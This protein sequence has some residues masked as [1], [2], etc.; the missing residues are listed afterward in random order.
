M[1][2]VSIYIHIPFCMHRCGYCDFNTYA[3]LEGLIP[4]YAQAVCNE[5]TYLSSIS[6]DPILVGTIYFGGGT[7][8][9][10]PIR[11]LENILSS[12]QNHFNLDESIEISLEANPG[13]VSKKFL[14]EINSLGVNRLSL[15]MQSSN[16][17]ELDLLER[18][19]RYV[20]VINAVEWARATGLKS[21]NLDLIFGLPEQSVETWMVNLESALS[22]NPEHLSL[23]ALTIEV[24]TPIYR[25]VK[26]GIFPE[27]DQ[28]VVADMYESASERLADAGFV[29]Y[30]ISNWALCDKSGGL[31]ACEHNLQYWRNLPYLGLGAGAHGFINHQRTINILNPRKYVDR[32]TDRSKRSGSEISFPWT[33]AVQEITPID[34]DTEIGETMMMGLRLTVEGVSTKKFKQ[35]YGMSLQERFGSQIDRL[36]GYDLLEWAGTDY[37][38][39]R[40]SKK[41]RLLGNQ[42]FKEFI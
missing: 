42:V 4:S 16:Q 27:P 41:G 18:Q 34:V 32:L 6:N 19:H 20:D 15:G 24:N 2:L 36:L 29:Q 23:Y 28:D 14:Q 40:L 17:D 1:Q 11:D 37:E 7:P 33:P 21:V 22:L 25:K 10:L 8:S 35:R 5:I 30:E 31:Y 39:L 13:T 12:I 26:T 38:I 9:L 3:G